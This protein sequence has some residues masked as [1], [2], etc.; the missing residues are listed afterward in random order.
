[1]RRFFP[2]FFTWLFAFHFY[3]H[4]TW[5]ETPSSSGSGFAVSND[6]WI[7]TNAHV[8]KGCQRIE[9]SNMGKGQDIRID[10]NNDLALLKLPDG[11]KTKTLYLRRD[12]IRLGE[13]IIALGFPLDGFLSDSIKMT[14]GNVS[15]LSGVE[16][17]TRYLQIS[18]P[19]QPG[20]SGGPVIDR[21]GHVIGITTA[22]L[23][24]SFA[25]ESGFIAQNVNFAVRSTV[26]EMFMQAQGVKISYAEDDK[27]VAPRSSTADIA[28][29]ASP[30][31]FKILCFEDETPEPQLSS[32]KSDEETEDEAFFYQDNYDAVGFD[33]KTLKDKSFGECSQACE[34]EKSCQAFT[35]NRRFHWC[36]LKNEV[37][38]LIRNRDADCGY[39]SEK[40]KEV[41]ITD[42]TAYSDVDITAGDYKRIDD[43]NY[44]GCFWGCVG[45]GNCK[46]YSFIPKKKQCWLKNKIG[47]LQE[48]KG[49]ESGMKSEER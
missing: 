15:A 43:T 38:A 3:S 39:R 25:D 2:L 16:N 42:F 26:A 11:I 23:S 44:F 36:L 14:T 20:N 27:N 4:L 8:V 21:N 48:K 35:Y 30:S 5:A 17:D 9:V 29:S 34:D 49:V 47:N 1:M 10:T 31:V 24:K 32:A 6:G 46:A 45:D 40:K 7:L 41:R 13:D 33:Y 18:T 37:F 12:V 19:I 22:G 28:E